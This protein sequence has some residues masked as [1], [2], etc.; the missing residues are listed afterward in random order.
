MGGR[1]PLLGG[2]TE[3]EQVPSYLQYIHTISQNREQ[4][5]ARDVGHYRGHHGYDHKGRKKVEI[6]RDDKDYKDGRKKVAKVLTEEE[7]IEKRKADA[8][9]ALAEKIKH[10]T[11][12]EISLLGG[13]DAAAAYV[14]AKDEDD[15]FYAIARRSFHH[16]QAAREAQV[17]L[18]AKEPPAS[19]SRLTPYKR[20]EKLAP[21]QMKNKRPKMRQATD[22]VETAPAPGREDSS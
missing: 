14:D 9:R 12:A 6:F 4:Y 18:E 17:A 2:G 7:L 5:E 11:A 1:P 10:F 22:D 19:C 3:L 20:K 15:F 8:A 13:Q 21:E 16:E